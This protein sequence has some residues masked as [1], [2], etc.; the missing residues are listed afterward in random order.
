MKIGGQIADVYDS[1]YTELTG[2]HTATPDGPLTAVLVRRAVVGFLY[3]GL[4]TS[5][6]ESKGNVY[7]NY[8]LSGVVMIPACVSVFLILRR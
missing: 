7:L 1:T 8:G 2:Q 4:T 5:T 3:F 6:M